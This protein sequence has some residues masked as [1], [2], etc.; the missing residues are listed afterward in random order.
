MQVLM[1]L[2][3]AGELAARLL[4]AARAAAEAANVPISNDLPAHVS[5]A[6]LLL[7]MIHRKVSASLYSDWS[8]L[9]HSL[10]V[11]V[12]MLSC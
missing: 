5:E 12:L 4:A 6:A 7:V 3:C 11:R 10:L 9:L 8:R 1:I 2:T